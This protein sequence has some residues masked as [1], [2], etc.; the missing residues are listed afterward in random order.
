MTVT[1]AL[2]IEVSRRIREDFENG[3]HY[4]ALHG[5]AVRAPAE[6]GERPSAEFLRWHNEEAY[7]G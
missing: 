6:P 4:Y 1:P 3:R 7:L 2:E 5:E